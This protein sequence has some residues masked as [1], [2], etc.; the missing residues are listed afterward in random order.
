MFR[1]VGRLDDSLDVVSTGAGDSGGGRVMMDLGRLDLLQITLIVR[2]LAA[3]ERAFESV[4][5]LRVAYRDPSVDLWGLENIVLPMGTTFI[6]VLSPRRDDTAG[7]R[8][9]ERQG[10]DAGYM[11]ILQTRDLAPWREWIGALGLRIAFEAET[12]DPD[13]GQDWSGIHLHPSDT[14]GM[15][16]SLDRPDPP[17]SWAGAGPRWRDFIC[18]DVVDG[19]VGIELRSPDPTRLSSRWGEVLGRSVDDRGRIALDRGTI[20]FRETLAG[21]IEGLSAIELRATNRERVGGR[22]DLAGVEFRLV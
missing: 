11:V 16:I 22:V 13:K 19:L 21:E 18:Q 7:G 17:E 8:H 9:L 5:G 1:R 2:D 20:G 6:E 14:G 12:R 10:G 15:M 3:V 4:L